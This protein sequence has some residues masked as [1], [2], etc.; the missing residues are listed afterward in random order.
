MHFY[1]YDLKSVSGLIGCRRILSIYPVCGVSLPGIT[2]YAVGCFY[3]RGKDFGIP[4]FMQF[5]TKKNRLA[6]FALAS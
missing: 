5:E 6:A 2:H 1:L 4:H 3:V